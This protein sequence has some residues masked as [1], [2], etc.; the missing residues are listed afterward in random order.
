MNNALNDFLISNKNNNKGIV[1]EGITQEEIL[2][3]FFAIIKIAKKFYI[4]EQFKNEVRD[5]LINSVKF[6]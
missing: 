4:N 6:L 1:L 2:D 5:Y 3:A